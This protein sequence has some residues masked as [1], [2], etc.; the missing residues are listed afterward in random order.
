MC[1]LYYKKSRTLHKEQTRQKKAELH[2]LNLCRNR[3]CSLLLEDDLDKPPF[4]TNSRDQDPSGDY[5]F[6][7]QIL[8]EPMTTDLRAIATNSQR[9]AE[10]VQYSVENQNPT[11]YLL[12]YTQG[13]KSVFAKDSFDILLEHC[14][15]NYAIELILGSEPK[16]SKVY[17][18]SPVE[19]TELDVFLEEN[20]YTGY[21]C[22]SKSPMAI[23]V[24]FIKKK[25]SSLQL[26]QDYHTLNS[27]I[28]KNWYSL[29]FISKLVF[30][31]YRAKYLTK[32]DVCQGF[33]NMHIKPRDEQKTTFWTNHKLFQLLVMFFGMTNSPATFQTIMNNIFQDLIIEGI[34]VMYLDDILIF[35]R[36]VEEHAQTIQKVLEILTEY[37][38]FLHSKKC[39]FQ[40]M[41]IEYLGLII[42][43]NKVSVNPVKVSRV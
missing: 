19:Q 32:L 17:P 26:V 31:L 1:F 10:N 39:K 28:V 43:E 24:F 15:Q 41:R 7:T 27:I 35:T 38:L 21:I 34:I 3:P 18:L 36:I 8:L 29:L 30:Q 40:K 9:L 42:L 4:S 5:L 14:C 37:K 20:L 16:L 13:F 12:E 11:V 25:N 33:N 6:I 22:L 23:L 2:T